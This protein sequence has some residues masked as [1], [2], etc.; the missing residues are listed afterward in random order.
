MAVGNA[1]R[2]LRIAQCAV[3][4]VAD[5]WRCERRVARPSAV[6]A[7]CLLERRLGGA[8]G[9]GLGPADTVKEYLYTQGNL[10]LQI[11]MSF[12]E[13]GHIDTYDR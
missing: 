2:A 3:Q 7:Q 10:A 12:E 13:L 4:R 11:D 8:S 1:S 9:S 6:R 5:A